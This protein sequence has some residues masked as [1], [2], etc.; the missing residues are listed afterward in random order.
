MAQLRALCVY[1]GASGRGD[2]RHRG[3]AAELGR[4]AAQ[5]GV[6]IVF[7]GGHV[8]MMGAVADGAL[9][10]GGRVTG[11]IPRHLLVREVEHRGLTEMIVV[12]S[13]HM[14]KQRMVELSDAF[15]ILPGGLGTLDEMFEILTWRQ[16]GLHDKPVV[17]LNFDGFWEP[18]VHLLD[19]LVS[20]GYTHREHTRLWQVVTRPEQV[21]E[22]VSAAPTPCR[23]SDIRRL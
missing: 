16:L 14:R 20:A 10:A 8:G 4:M 22:A 21:F 11:V 19:H 7:G 2:P 1:C 9:A 3:M 23:P 12:E 6:G 5:R 17:V 15:C 18:L 13:M